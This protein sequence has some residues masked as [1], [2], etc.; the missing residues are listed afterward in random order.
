MREQ[1]HRRER[2]G[3]YPAEARLQSENAG[4]RARNADRPGAV[5][6]EMQGPDPGGARRGGA[7]AAAA[8]GAREVPRV[9]RDPGQRAVA[10]RFP[11]E[12]RCR[13]LA[14]DDS[15]GLAQPRRRRRV[16]GPVLVRIDEA[17]P[18]QGREAAHQ[19][20]V[21]DRHRNAVEPP[22]RLSAQP[23]LFRCPRRSHR[24]VVVDDA[25]GVDFGLQPIEAIEQ[26]PGHFDRRERSLAI[27]IE[28][29][30]RRRVGDILVGAHCCSFLPLPKNNL[31]RGF[32]SV[33]PDRVRSFHNEG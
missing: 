13:R 10:Q 29:R 5:A 21:L 8:R 17:R 27:E 2:V 23:A 32:C 26:Q 9:A 3:R 15:T 11:A 18:A 33:N 22:D 19:H 7:G 12:F 25:E 16:L 1:A 31:W 4:E 24:A 20:Q 30:N 6:A 14:E 28:Q